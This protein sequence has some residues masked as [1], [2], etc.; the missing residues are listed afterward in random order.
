MKKIIMGIVAFASVSVFALDVQRVVTV[1]QKPDDWSQFRSIDGVLNQAHAGKLVLNGS[2]MS[3]T[4]NAEIIDIGNDNDEYDLQKALKK[5]SKTHP[6]E[7][8]IQ[9]GKIKALRIH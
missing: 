7:I 5:A 3:S 8:V 9:N 1:E 2:F 6:V 4:T